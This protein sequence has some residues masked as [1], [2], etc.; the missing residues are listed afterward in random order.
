MTSI[1]EIKKKIEN[2]NFIRVENVSNNCYYV[3]KSDLVVEKFKASFLGKFGRNGL[4]N[5]LQKFKFFH[6]YTATISLRV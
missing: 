4:K 6:L 5:S 1:E 3:L 2:R